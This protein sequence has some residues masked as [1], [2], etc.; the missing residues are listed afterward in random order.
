MTIFVL[1]I[2]PKKVINKFLAEKFKISAQ[3]IAFWK[4]WQIG[5]KKQK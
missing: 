2:W 4:Q 1:Q 5:G 3:A